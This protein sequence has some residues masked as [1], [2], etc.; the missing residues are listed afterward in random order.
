MPLINSLFASH[1][2][3]MTTP[4]KK[5]TTWDAHLPLVLLACGTVA[6]ACLA[7]VLTDHLHATRRYS[8]KAILHQVKQ[9]VTSQGHSVEGS[10]IEV[11]PI[12]IERFN[13]SQQVYYGGFSYRDAQQMQQFEFYVDPK[14]SHIL[15]VFPAH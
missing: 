15:D 10:W 14:T 8:A 9:Y 2:E 1:P 5:A 3:E 13:Q 11:E 4:E 12:T 7:A 6:G